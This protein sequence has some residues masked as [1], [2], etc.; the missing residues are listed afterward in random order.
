MSTSYRPI[1]AI[2]FQ[3]L[4]DGCLDKHS[5]RA[6]ADPD[7]AAGR[8]RLVGSDGILEV[9]EE[10]D[11]ASI[12][13]RRS[14]TPIPWS[15]IDALTEEFGVELVSEHDH[16]YSGFATKEEETEF[17]E[18]I[19]KE[20]EDK[21][22]QDVLHHLR[23]EPNGLKTGTVGMLQAEI[24]KDL[25][26]RDESLMWPESRQKLLE[27]VNAIYRRDHCITVTLIPEDMG[28]VELMVARTNKLP[29][30]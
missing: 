19:A 1:P 13:Q 26:T 16:R 7:G 18:R 21:F 25:V 23:G 2:P 22:Y 14:F 5:I 27:T 28:A 9:Y 12:F 17:H 4:F 3:M 6:E 11:G 30:A 29:N 24:A 8:R 20:S 10:D 15:V